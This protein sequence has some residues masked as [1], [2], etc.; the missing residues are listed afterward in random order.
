MSRSTPRTGAGSRE[1]DGGG[2]ADQSR[3]TKDRRIFKITW[4][5]S[6]YIRTRGAWRCTQIGL[7]SVAHARGNELAWTYVPPE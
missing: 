7:T 5:K 2:L 6:S 1:A 3:Q 4:R